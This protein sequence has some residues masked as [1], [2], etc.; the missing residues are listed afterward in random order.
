MAVTF[1]FDELPKEIRNMIHREAITFSGDDGVVWIPRCV[2]RISPDDSAELS[3]AYEDE[4]DDEDDEN[5][6]DPHSGDEEEEDY[7]RGLYTGE[8]QEPERDSED[9]YRVDIA[10]MHGTCGPLNEPAV[11]FLNRESRAESR[12]LSYTQNAFS[13]HFD[14]HDY[15]HSLG[16][17]FDWAKAE[18]LPTERHKAVLIR[19]ISFEGCSVV[20]EGVKFNV[21]IDLTDE[22]PFFKVHAEYFDSSDFSIDRIRAQLREAITARLEVMVEKAG[23]ARFAF[24]AWDLMDL[25]Q[26]FKEVMTGEDD[27]RESHAVRRS[28][29]A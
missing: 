6:I 15:D 9:A 25:A 3:E 14:R 26:E 29:C 24:R 21:D 4:V 23:C 2:P 11:L 1:R 18:G 10:A 20:E 19:Q 27:D 5:D 22:A 17:F 8:N 16:R 28:R 7:D 12:E 13:I